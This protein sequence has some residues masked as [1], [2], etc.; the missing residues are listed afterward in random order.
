M[1]NFTGFPDHLPIPTIFLFLFPIFHT[2]VKKSSHLPRQKI[3]RPQTRQTTHSRRFFQ[4]R[5]G[6]LA[7]RRPTWLTCSAS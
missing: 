4:Q 5:A 6:K 1:L 2:T 3:R 7:E